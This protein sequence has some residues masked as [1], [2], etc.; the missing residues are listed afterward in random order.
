[1]DGTEAEVLSQGTTEKLL[2]ANRLSPFHLNRSFVH[3]YQ[4]A[5]C[6]KQY[7]LTALSVFVVNWSLVSK[8]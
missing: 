1:M 5:G 7:H 8:S 6:A 4:E 2:T 3:Q